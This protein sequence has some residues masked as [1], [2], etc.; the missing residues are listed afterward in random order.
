MKNKQSAHTNVCRPCSCSP[1]RIRLREPGQNWRFCCS[2]NPKIHKSSIIFFRTT[3]PA[4]G[5]LA[6]HTKIMFLLG[7][8]Y[9]LPFFHAAKVCSV[10]ILSKFIPVQI[11]S[12]MSR[13][14]CL[15]V[16]WK[17]KCSFVPVFNLTGRCSKAVKDILKI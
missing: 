1:L 9:G 12:N 5:L 14:S 8:Q 2:G 15:P 11:S 16:F 10:C 17:K 6:G 4:A 3:C 7:S 13:C